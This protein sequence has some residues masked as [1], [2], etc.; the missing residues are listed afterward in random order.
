MSAAAA[1]AT[2]PGGGVQVPEPEPFESVERQHGKEEEEKEVRDPCCWGSW[3]RVAG[4]EDGGVEVCARGGAGEPVATAE[5]GGA[6]AAARFGSDGFVILPRLITAEAAAVLNARLE[7][8][9]RGEFD[10]GTPPDKR[11]KVFASLFTPPPPPIPPHGGAHGRDGDDD[12][13]WCRRGAR[14][15]GLR[16]G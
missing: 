11:P 3:Q 6:A 13:G 10:T 9:L 12:D 1:S 7:R 8:V 4:G 14:S 5:G 2:A 15:S 16:S